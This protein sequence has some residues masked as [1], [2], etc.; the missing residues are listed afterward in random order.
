MWSSGNLKGHYLDVKNFL[1]NF[2]NKTYVYFWVNYKSVKKKYTYSINK[3]TSNQINPLTVK[4]GSWTCQLKES[5]FFPT[6]RTTKSTKTASLFEF[7]GV[8]GW[9]EILSFL[10][11]PMIPMT[12]KEYHA[13]DPND[14]KR[15]AFPN[16]WLSLNRVLKKNLPI[17]RISR[18]TQ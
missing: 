15:V 18:L 11:T 4:I 6:K 16:Y 13:T 14:F 8:D 5:I 12:L 1:N 2:P 3:I 9:S 10:A 17:C 7:K